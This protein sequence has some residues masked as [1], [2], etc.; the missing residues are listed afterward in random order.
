MTTPAGFKFN[1]QTPDGSNGGV[2]EATV[3]RTL[4]NSASPSVETGPIIRYWTQVAAGRL[5]F[6]IVSGFTTNL[7]AQLSSV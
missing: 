4:F 2:S 1:A 3:P 7:F 5:S 6:D